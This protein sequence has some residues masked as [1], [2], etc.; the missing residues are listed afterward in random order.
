MKRTA[1]AFILCCT[2]LAL[3]GCDWRGSERSPASDI[4]MATSI[5]PAT[6]ALRIELTSTKDDKSSAL[7]P[8]TLDFSFEES[9][10][11]CQASSDCVLMQVGACDKVQAIHRSQIEVAQ[12]YSERSKKEYPN[13]Q[14]APGWPIEYYE[15]L[16]LNQKCRAVQKDYRMLLE[17]PEQPVAGQPFWVGISFRIPTTVE[18]MN[19]HLSLPDSVKVVGGEASWSGR[20]EAN[21]D[22]VLWAKLLTDTPG[23]VYLTAWAKAQDDAAFSPLS[24]SEHIEVASPY[25]L[26]PWPERERLLATP[27]PIKQ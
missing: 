1:M 17:V 20:A 19:A 26:T 11:A 2:M 7:A 14:C 23:Q 24:C 6:V 4:E 15:P 13:I 8:P 22:Y 27:T 9:R 21:Q 25:S 16:C 5:V 12:A 18:Q 3:A 10:A